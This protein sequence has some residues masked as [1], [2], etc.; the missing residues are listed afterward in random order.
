M[1]SD[2]IAAALAETAPITPPQYLLSALD[3]SE[4]V[5][6]KV[7]ECVE[8]LSAITSILK[9][10]VS[11][12]LPL[13]II[14]GAFNRSEE[15]EQ[16][17]QQCADDLAAV[18]LALAREISERKFLEG[19][20]F[21]SKIEQQQTRYLAFHDAVSGLPNRALFNDRLHQ[22]LAQARRHQRGFA[23]LF[24]DLDN[25]KQVNDRYG[26]A[27]GDEVLR[28]VAERLKASVR[29]EDT[30]SR[31]GGDEFLC[32]LLEVA[33]RERAAA[34]VEKIVRNLNQP[35]VIGGIRLN[36]A[37]SVGVTLAPADGSDIEALVNNADAAMYI[38][39]RNAKSGADERGYR[40]FQEVG[41]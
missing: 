29:T 11:E 26:H 12:H 24:I 17:V 20:L 31:H 5:K 23:I 15:I 38:A 30:V 25:F 34:I 33:D 16:K 21:R 27:V 35:Y 2:H 13:E 39:K 40:F 8:E 19:E 37:A 10:E 4:L 32:L 3:Q 14:A 9:D 36:V 41:G 7:E 22:A 18:N 28:G 1:T 6:Q